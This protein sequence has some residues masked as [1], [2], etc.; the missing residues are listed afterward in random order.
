VT[1]LAHELAGLIGPLH[2]LVSE[3]QS[4]AQK[5]ERRSTSNAQTPTRPLGQIQPSGEPKKSTRRSRAAARPG[6]CRAGASKSIA[7]ANGSYCT[8]CAQS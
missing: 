7:A 4:S 5:I 1:A 6:L 3:F 8:Q 2:R